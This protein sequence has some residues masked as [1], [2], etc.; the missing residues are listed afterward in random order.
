MVIDKLTLSRLIE[1]EFVTVQEGY[2]ITF[3]N[4]EKEFFARGLQI[5]FYVLCR[6]A[7]ITEQFVSG[8]VPQYLIMFEG[9]TEK[10]NF[11]QEAMT[12]ISYNHPPTHI[13]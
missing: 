4:R 12:F 5:S 1:K 2:G 10:K 8:K 9:T 11:F 7:V 13:K 6:R 3:D